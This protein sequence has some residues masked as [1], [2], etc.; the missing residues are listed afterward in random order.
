MVEANK[1]AIIYSATINRFMAYCKKGVLLDEG[2]FSQSYNV[3]I[4]YSLMH[5]I[6]KPSPAV[7]SNV[8]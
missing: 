1:N 8:A 6:A 7:A 4:Y 3:Q 5:L 2:A